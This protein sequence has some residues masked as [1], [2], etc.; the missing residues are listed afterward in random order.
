MQSNKKILRQFFPLKLA[1]CWDGGGSKPQRDQEESLWS[2]RNHRTP[3]P[4]LAWCVW[5]TV[6]GTGVPA[7]VT[8]G[9]AR[10][11]RPAT[12][13]Q[14]GDWE[15]SRVTCSEYIF[16]DF[17]FSGCSVDGKGHGERRRGGWRNL[18]WKQY[19]LW[20]SEGKTDKLQVVW[21]GGMTVRDNAKVFYP[22]QLCWEKM[23]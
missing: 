15:W 11:R 7:A 22:D 10:V 18:E 8:R 1:F 13:I 3:R 21:F 14:S 4:K 2:I 6:R 16:I 9:G 17:R 19:R 23:S 20:E 12:Y 5:V